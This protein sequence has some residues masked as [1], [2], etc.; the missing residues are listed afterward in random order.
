M[1]PA[2]VA[3][4]SAPGR[5]AR[6]RPLCW[7]T[8][9]WCSRS[10][11]RSSRSAASSWRSRSCRWPCSRAGTACGPSSRARSPPRLSASSCSVPRPSLRWSGAGRVGRG[12]R[13][14][15]RGADWGFA[16]TVGDAVVF[17]WPTVAVGADL[18]LWVFSA[19]RRLVLV[20][21]HNAWSGVS[22]ALRNHHVAAL[23]DPRAPWGSLSSRMS[24]GRG[25]SR[26]RSDCSWRSSSPPRSR[27][28]SPGRRCD[29]C[30]PR[31]RSTTKA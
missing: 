6:R 16:R 23:T 27:S 2:G 30:A 21:I 3:T 13:R 9:R 26:S 31:S 22:R 29:E 8:S 14:R 10:R 7:P 15:R 12:R 4:R 28:A 1:H 5:R 11:A 20:Q 25:G 19:Y 24:C 18:L 17:L